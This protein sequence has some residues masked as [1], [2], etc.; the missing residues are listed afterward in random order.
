MSTK[1]KQIKY[2]EVQ[3]SDEVFDPRNMKE[4]ITIFLD[5]DIIDHFRLEAK[6]EGTGYQTLINSALKSHVIKTPIEK[7]LEMIEKKLDR[8]AK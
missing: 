8:L 2:C 7:R 3:I 1:K 4:R 6:K 5:E